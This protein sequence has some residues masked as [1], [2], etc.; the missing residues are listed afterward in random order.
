M[1]GSAT[2]CT[3]EGYFRHHPY[4]RISSLLLVSL[5]LLVGAPGLRADELRLPDP[6]TFGPQLDG[7]GFLV[8]EAPET[9]DAGAAIV[10]LNGHFASAPF[11]P[12]GMQD[13]RDINRIVQTS[14]SGGYGL[15]EF[16]SAGISVPIRLDQDVTG[17]DVRG[18]GL[19]DLGIWG[20]AQIL[21]EVGGPFSLGVVGHLFLPTG[22]VQHLLGDGR[23][24]GQLVGSAGRHAGPFLLLVNIGYRLRSGELDY[25]GLVYRDELL[26]GAGIA[27]LENSRRYMVEVYGSS[28]EVELFARGL[29]PIEVMAGIRQSL[30]PAWTI[31]VG[32]GRGVTD[33]HGSPAFRA[34]GVLRFS[35][36]ANGEPV[37]AE[38]ALTSVSRLG[39]DI[40]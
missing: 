32:A 27:Y 13:V 37:D 38:Q 7:L 16:I 21:T 34:I 8:A 35:L 23:W 33:S 20:K 18:F 36:P 11:V 25:L 39:G 31:D 26:F 14:L 5:I 17:R 30:T 1:Q 22:S 29:T 3:V 6:Q 4:M 24:R 40:P 9:L 2:H 28:P 15:T 12:E 19:G 10:N